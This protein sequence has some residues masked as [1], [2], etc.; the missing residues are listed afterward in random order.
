MNRE[1]PRSTRQNAKLYAKTRHF[2]VLCAVFVFSSI[3]IFTGCT[4][5]EAAASRTQTTT[6][7]AD[8]IQQRIAE[9]DNTNAVTVTATSANTDNA[10]VST[11]AGVAA[12]TATT[13]NAD[14]AGVAP[15]PTQ[16]ETVAQIANSAPTAAPT[17]QERVKPERPSSES[18]S[19][20][21]D[22]TTLSSTMVY[23]EVL[24][25][26]TA[27]ETYVGKTVK[28]KGYF[29]YYHDENTDKYYFA[30]MIPD[31]TACCAQ[32]IEFILTD[33][34][35]FPDDYPEE[36]EV[37]TVAGEFMIYEEDG[38]TYFTLKDSKLLS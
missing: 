5:N 33:E 31:A 1:T 30:C 16:K 8:V 20:D 13:G 26:M 15:A 12:T 17:K 4:K 21:V 10:E 25:I 2:S 22:L 32:G 35:L 36:G 18:V 27:P 11:T 7:V 6:S 24:N 9:T 29:G 37:V 28:M 14:N 3:L 34:Y 38:S 19:V 23:S